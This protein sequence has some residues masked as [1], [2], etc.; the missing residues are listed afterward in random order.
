MREILFRGKR[1]DNGDWVYGAYITMHHNDGRTHIHHFIIPDGSNLSYGVKV[2]D[3]LVEV[4]VKT[5]CQCTS[6]TDKNGNNIFE[7]DF[8]KLKDER[9]G[10]E[11]MA[12]VGFGNL[13]GDYNWG[14]QL[15]RVKGDDLN[16]SIL[17]WTDMEGSAYAEIIGNVFDDQKLLE[18][19]E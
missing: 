16:T 5:I 14:F 11:C 13:N 15:A 19:N 4:D 18:V 2:E 10:G 17:L 3:I 12:F 6:L 8:L 1:I 9:N 7:G